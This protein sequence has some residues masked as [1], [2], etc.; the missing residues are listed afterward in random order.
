MKI[1]PHIR[2]NEFTK[3]FQCDIWADS[4]GEKCH[5]S[6]EGDTPIDAYDKFLVCLGWFWRDSPTEVPEF[7]STARYR[8]PSPKNR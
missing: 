5:V 2:F 6:G 4:P 7:R 1:K 3:K 8:Y